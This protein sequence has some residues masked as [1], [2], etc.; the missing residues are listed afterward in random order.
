MKD[1]F[2]NYDRWKLQY[3]PEWDEP[4]PED[5]EREDGHYDEMWDKSI[6]DT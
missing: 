2:A 1:P 3:P 4:H 5:T 6:R